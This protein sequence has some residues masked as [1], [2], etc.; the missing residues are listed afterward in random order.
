MQ[1]MQALKYYHHITV[2][3][4]QAKGNMYLYTLIKES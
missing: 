2:S 3:I 1:V 4:Q